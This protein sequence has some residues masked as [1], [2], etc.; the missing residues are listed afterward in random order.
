MRYSKAKYILPIAGTV[1]MVFLGAMYGVNPISSLMDYGS[2][3]KAKSVSKVGQ[4]NYLV[5]EM[6]HEKEI[7]LDIDLLR[8]EHYWHPQ[9]AIWTE[10]TEGNYLETIF[11]SKATAKGLF[12]GG[13][14]KENFKTFDEKQKSR[15]E[16]RRVNALPVWAHKRGVSNADGMYA[17]SSR[18]PLPDAITG[19]TLDDSFKLYTSVAYSKAFV[20]RLELNVAF[21]DNE[22]YSEYDFPDDATFHNGTGQLGQPSIIFETKIEIKKEKEH[23]LMKLVGHGHHSGQTGELYTDLSTLTTAKELVERIVVGVE[24]GTLEHHIVENK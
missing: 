10:D 16:Y 1:A 14:T 23:Y 11:V 20:L 6:G 24:H 22:Y 2:K 4:N 9:M 13:R 8:A 15:G 18:N 7:K 3:L 5:L 12:F 19:A 21:D 17:P